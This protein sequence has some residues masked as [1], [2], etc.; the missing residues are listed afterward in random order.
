MLNAHQRQ[1]EADPAQ[2]DRTERTT[3]AWTGRDAAAMLTSECSW[4]RRV[5]RSCAAVVV[6]VRGDDVSMVVIVVMIV[7]VVAARARNVA[8]GPDQPA[9]QE[10]VRSRC[11]ST[12]APTPTTS[13]PR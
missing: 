8:P 2:R 10:P 9:G 7:I 12:E 6:V 5:L 4:G 1:A 13:S 11:R 3:S